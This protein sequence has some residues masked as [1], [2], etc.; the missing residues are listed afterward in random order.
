M[1][2][3]CLRPTHCY[4][5]LSL[6]IMLPSTSAVHVLASS[7]H[8]LG[9]AISSAS[10]SLYYVCLSIIFMLISTSAMYVVVSLE[11]SRLGS[12]LSSVAVSLFHV[13]LSILLRFIPKVLC[14]PSFHC[15]HRES[16]P[17]GIEVTRLHLNIFL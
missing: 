6:L 11:P 8:R 3:C 14:M 12:A 5:I 13:C 1:N 7:G 9:T 4:F 17:I 10:F 16:Q 15:D 2:D